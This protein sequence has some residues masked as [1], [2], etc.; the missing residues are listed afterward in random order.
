MCNFSTLSPVPL[1][2]EKSSHDTLPFLDVTVQ[3]SD[4]RY[5]T[6]VYRKTSNAGLTM[7]GRSECPERY[8]QNVIR[9]FVR[10]ALRVCSSYDL[11]HVEFCRIKQLL[12]NN[13]YT[14]TDVDKEIKF[15]LDIHMNKQTKQS[16]STVSHLY[17]RNYMSSQYK[18]DEKVLKDIIS[19]NVKGTGDNVL[20]LHIYYQ[21]MKTRNLVMKNNPAKTEALKRTNVVY[22]F[23]CPNKIVGFV[24]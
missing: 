19:K 15:L 18:T 24:R 4:G 7:N 20:K 10:R 21:N 14:N 3:I 17:Y 9:A 2:Y 12:V 1:T 16:N 13:G 5:I 22:K 11:L 23:S 6:D 8:K